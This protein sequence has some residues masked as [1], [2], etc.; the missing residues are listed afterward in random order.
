MDINGFYDNYM[1]NHSKA[2]IDNF[3]QQISKQLLKGTSFN[4]TNNAIMNLSPQVISFHNSNIKL[5]S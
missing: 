4:C 2:H 3:M 5:S 1:I